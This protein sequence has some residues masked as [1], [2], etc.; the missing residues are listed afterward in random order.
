MVLTFLG[1][2]CSQADLAHQLDARAIVGTSQSRTE[3][4]RSDKINVTYAARGNADTLRQQIAHELPV[5]VFV[6]T[7]ELPYWHEHVSR[8]AIVVVRIDDVTVSVLDPAMPPEPLTVPL[9]DF[10]LAWDE[11]D[12]TYAVISLRR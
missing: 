6:Q 11:V 9:G 1:V 3:R 7:A 10:M 2:P 4:L 12:N 8:H 5:I